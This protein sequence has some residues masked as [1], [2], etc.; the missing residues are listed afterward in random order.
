MMMVTEEMN[1]KR[2]RVGRKSEGVAGYT[3]M[4]GYATGENSDLL[5]VGW[6]TIRDLVL[7]LLLVVQVGC[8]FL[9]WLLI[10]LRNSMPPEDPS[11]ASTPSSSINSEIIQESTYQPVPIMSTKIVPS[12]PLPQSPGAPYFEGHNVTEFLERFEDQ[13]EDAG[14]DDKVKVRRLPRYCSL[15]VGQYVKTLPEW[16]DQDWSMLHAALVSEYKDHDSIQQMNSRAFLEAL[17]DKKRETEA[18]TRAYIR[19]F[20]AI[21]AALLKKGQIEGYTRGIWFLNGLPQGIRS[22]VIRKQGINIEEPSTMI[23]DKMT[24]AAIE[25]LESNKTVREFDSDVRGREVLSQLVDQFGN[26]VQVPKEK[27]FSVPVVGPQAREVSNGTIEDLTRAFESLAMSA[28]ATANTIPSGQQAR[29]NPPGGAN[30]GAYPTGAT[31]RVDPSHPPRGPIAGAGVYA[32]ELY[33]SRPVIC[34]YCQEEGHFRRD[35]PDFVIDQ[36]RG[37]VHETLEGR[38]HYGRAGEGGKAV[39]VPRGARGRDI[40]REHWEAAAQQQAQA[41]TAGQAATR[42][43]LGRPT[44]V[45]SVGGMSG[46]VV[47]M[48]ESDDEELENEVDVRAAILRGDKRA[49]TEEQWKDPRRTLKERIQKERKMAAPKVPRA[50]NWK[51]PSVE[52]ADELDETMD[53][54]E[55]DIDKEQT[56][57]LRKA[58]PRVVRRVEKY[59][60]L[61]RRTA[62]PMELMNKILDNELKGVTARE[63]VACSDVLQKILFKN[64]ATAIPSDMRPKTGG[65]E[66]HV[67]SAMLE[68]IETPFIVTSPKVRVTIG[69]LEVLALIDSGA[70]A[71]LIS[72]RVAERAGLG[73][74]PEPQY[75]M[76]GHSGERKKFD[77]MCENVTVKIGSVG[78]TTN[79]FTMDNPQNDVVLGQPF[80]VA[81]LLT[82]SYRDGFQYA[83][84]VNDERTKQV[85]VRV[86][87]MTDSRREKNTLQ[88]N[89]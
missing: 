30:R 56:E 7:V 65:E 19:Q 3:R 83:T 78:T 72:S 35:C 80:I 81:S 62:N 67:Q 63:I 49:A 11:E 43:V 13:A 73:V 82:F 22:K 20:T 39:W 51:K 88:G 48:E 18:E 46:E 86:A 59:V 76:V 79:F 27:Q 23:Y 38:M 6:A 10:R 64:M 70:E 75:G 9:I 77:G 58:G 57:A 8:Q 24:K 44:G 34:F 74:R 68:E 15:A 55:I 17:K 4:K 41:T 1:V 53:V 66:V 26:T 69:D 71:D 31:G 29:F 52:V 50:G 40:I 61:I 16:V 28:R 33:R 36:E 45:T 25:I 85:T 32:G 12:V 42:T 21:S 84:M 5:K 89:L 60:D 37:L 2:K 47:R 87:S 14:W 54:E